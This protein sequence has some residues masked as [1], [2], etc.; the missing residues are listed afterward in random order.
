MVQKNLESLGITPEERSTL[1]EQH[2]ASFAQYRAMRDR[3]NNPS[4]EKFDDF[5]KWIQAIDS[6]SADR[7]TGVALLSY[8]EDSKTTGAQDFI[9]KIANDYHGSGAGDELLIPLIEGSASGR[10]SFP[11]DKARGLATKISDDKLREELLQKLN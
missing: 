1:I 4:R 3:G 9:E 7:A 8:L 10:V 5:R 11:K 2:F 6:S